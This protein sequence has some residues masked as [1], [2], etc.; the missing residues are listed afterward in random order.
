ME[1]VHKELGDRMERAATTTSSLE[2]E[3]DSG[4]GTRCQDTILGDVNAQTRYSLMLANPG[5]GLQPL[6]VLGNL[7]VTGNEHALGH[8]LEGQCKSTIGVSNCLFSL[9]EANSVE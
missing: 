3:Q 8:T 6:A 7:Q 1:A 2:A 5:F 4:S 9:I